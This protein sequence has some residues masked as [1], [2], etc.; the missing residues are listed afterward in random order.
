LIFLQDYLVVDL[1]AV[2]FLL[3]DKLFL[4]GGYLLHLLNHHFLHLHQD[5]VM[6]IHHQNH[7]LLMIYLKKLMRIQQFLL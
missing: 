4:M 5:L 3:L 1:L 2:Y 7:H 6:V